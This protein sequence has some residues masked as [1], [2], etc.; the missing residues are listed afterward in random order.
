L[1]S[2]PQP[3]PQRQEWNQ[4]PR[5]QPLSLKLAGLGTDLLQYLVI[6]LGD[7]REATSVIDKTLN[8]RWNQTFDLPVS[9]ISS[10]LLEAVCW[11]KDRFS[12]DYMGEF[13]VALEDIF[14][15]GKT[16]QEAS[17]TPNTRLRHDLQLTSSSGQMV[18][19]RI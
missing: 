18:Q 7:A 15:N 5:K 6:T 9:G 14:T 11:D 1:S 19:A 8:P 13:D 3:R 2:G 10:L 12:K 17:T 4:R 16:A